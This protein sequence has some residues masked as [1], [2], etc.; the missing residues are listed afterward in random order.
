MAKKKEQELAKRYFIDFFKTQKEIAEELGVT[1]KTV[2]SWVTKYNWKA[3]RDA[4]LNNS[5]NRAENIKKVISELTESTLDVLEQIKVAEFNGDKPEVLR[6]KKETTRI[7]QEVG[8][9]QKALEKMEKDFKT[10]LSTYMEVMEDIF[11]SLSNY[12]KELYL[13]TIDFQRAHIQSIANK[14]G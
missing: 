3:L 9:Y 14:L 5:T 4:K 7:A 6:L 12:D 8:M 13:Q 11:Q 10:S 1:E 2:S